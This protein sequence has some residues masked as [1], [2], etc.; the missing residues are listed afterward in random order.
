MEIVMDCPPSSCAGGIKHQSQTKLSKIGSI[1]PSV[2][3]I[4]FSIPLVF[5][6]CSPLLLRHN[7]ITIHFVKDQSSKQGIC[8][9][10]AT[11]LLIYNS[12]RENEGST[13]ERTRSLAFFDIIIFLDLLGFFRHR[14]PILFQ[15]CKPDITT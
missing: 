15:R 7:K 5:S 3:G 14:R 11:S 13:I 2:F 6:D 9:W 4:R 8:W 1:H 10:K 12:V